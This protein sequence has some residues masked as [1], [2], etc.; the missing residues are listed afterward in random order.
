MQNLHAVQDV[1][2]MIR[3]GRPFSVKAIPQKLSAVSKKQQPEFKSISHVFEYFFREERFSPGALKGHDISN[4]QS[5]R[6]NKTKVDEI[7]QEVV[8]QIE[9][10]LH[11]DPGG[12]N[13]HGAVIDLIRVLKDT[14]DGSPPLSCLSGVKQVIYNVCNKSLEKMEA[15]LVRRLPPSDFEKIIKRAMIQRITNINLFLYLVSVASSIFR[16]R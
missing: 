12:F 15:Y 4:K 10:S 11:L 2:C 16:R 7:S 14:G 8:S 5:A 6:I 1:L 3:S 13:L 9:S